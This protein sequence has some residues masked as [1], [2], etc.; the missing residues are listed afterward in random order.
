MHHLNRSAVAACLGLAFLMLPAAPSH[1]ITQCNG[2][3]GFDAS[4]D[5]VHCSYQHPVPD[6]HWRST[7]HHRW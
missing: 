1:P 2:D 6:R 4:R 3:P 7:H 5:P